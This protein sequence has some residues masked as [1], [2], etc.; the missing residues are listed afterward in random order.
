[1]KKTISI[2]LTLILTAGLF[3]PAFSDTASAASEWGP[4]SEWQDSY[5]AGSSTRQVE[6][7]SE[8]VGYFMVLYQTQ[9]ANYP[10]YRNFRG[11][12]V[13]GNYA[14]YGLRA[15]YGEHH[16]THYFSKATLDSA[17]RHYNGNYLSYR[18]EASGYQR[19]SAT[20]YL[21]ISTGL[22][23]FIQ[24][25]DTRTQYRY[26]DQ[27]AVPV[28][29]VI[30]RDWDGRSL[31][32][33]KVERGQ[34][35][36]PPTNPNRE[37]YTFIGWDR[38][39]DNIQADIIVYALYTENASH[40]SVTSITGVPT[41]ATA[42]TPLTLNGTVNPSNATSRT[43]AWSVVSA[44]TTGA[45][46]SGNTLNTTAAGTAT[47]RATIANGRAVGSNYTQDFTITISAD[48][49]PVTSITGVPTT[50]IAG[51]P[52]T[53]N[54]T[55]NPSNATN[56]TIT[57]AITSGGAAGATISGNTLNTTA[58]GTVMLRATVFNGRAVGS[59]YTQDF[60]ITVSTAH[61]PVTS[62]T[63]VPTAATAGTP[64]TLNGTVNP[65]NATNRTITW[66]I[67]SA[68]TT[69]AT[70]SGNTLNTTAA[71]TVTVRATIINGS[72]ASSNYTQTFNITVIAQNTR[73]MFRPTVDGYSFVNSASSFGYQGRY[74]IPEQRWIEVYGQATGAAYYN[75]F[76]RS[77]WGGSCFGFSV[78]STKFYNN[79]LNISNYGFSRVYDIPAPR[80]TTHPVTQLI[81]RGQISWYLRGV[82][83]VNFDRNAL[84]SAAENFADNRTNPIILY[85]DAQNYT[86]A[87][88]PWKIE[89]SGY[90]T[91]IYVYDNNRP[92]REDIY[93]TIHGSGSF[94]SNYGIPPINR[95]GFIRLQQVLDGESSVPRGFMHISVDKQAAQILTATG[96]SVENLEGAQKIEPMPAN[97]IGETHFTA[98]WLPIGDYTVVVQGDAPVRLAISEDGEAYTI[99]LLPS[100]NGVTVEIADAVDI[101]GA[102]HGNIIEYHDDG[103][104][105]LLP[106]MPAIAVELM[107][108]ST[109]ETGF[110]DVA[111]SAWY[112]RAIT[113]AA[114]VGIIEGV[115]GNRYD[116]QGTLTV[117]QLVTMLMRT[118]YGRLSG[119]GTWYSAYI[120]RARLDGVILDSDDFEPTSQITR[121]QAAQ[122]LTRYIEKYNPRW[123]KN[124][125]D[126]APTDLESV[127]AR[128]RDA[129]ISAYSWGLVSG[130]NN[131]RYNPQNTLSR[132]EAAQLLYNYYSIVD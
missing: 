26:R 81:E 100:N 130:D 17:T 20:S 1:M 93:F 50:A 29:V 119:S 116:P 33:Q 86:H 31:K 3:M 111:P 122:I 61:I 54:G 71:G 16:W 97:G 4:W 44:G 107:P 30:F 55:V 63:G 77:A 74:V 12:S 118:Q 69:G 47:I 48:H 22:P 83:S 80:S 88:V 113:S 99:N 23:W 60:T 56:R 52:L 104:E 73:A 64:L 18:S 14:A 115:G 53:L 92:G 123:A 11:F 125:V 84:I 65:S 109:A 103:T 6:T 45:T 87:V 46:I 102:V 35:A 112:N 127:P 58:A 114:T 59:H 126:K 42:G 19:D 24:S 131:G 32:E 66:S 25:E 34:S 132:A 82:P 43:I 89:R 5:I 41:A 124:R 76:G 38:K 62:I 9:E 101:T 28:F 21:D 85:I 129:V 72:T 68:G 78:T 39:Y 27:I 7:R 105:L 13:N 110:I 8:V 51:T 15:S 108:G 120:E 117:A 90:D 121:A 40:V 98:Y 91:R 96:Q 36:T 106:V 70:I 57:W 128:Y 94:S 79:N 49:I 2:L 10:N 75:Q 67:A 95:L 37:G